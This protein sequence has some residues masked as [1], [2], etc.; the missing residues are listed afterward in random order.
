MNFSAKT[1][2]MPKNKLLPDER[3]EQIALCQ[4][5]DIKRIDYF[6]IPNGG[7]RHLLTAIKLKQ[8]GVKSGVSDMAIFLPDKIL[9][10]EMKKQK[11]GVQSDTQKAFEQIV[12]KYPYARYELA[13]GFV[14]AKEIIEKEIKR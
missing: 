3:T 12:S 4:W 13:R 6:A 2:S 11:G 7:H 10:L 9:F 14:K 1:R 5:L 8:E